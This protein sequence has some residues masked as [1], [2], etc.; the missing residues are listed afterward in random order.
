MDQ[1]TLEVDLH[2]VNNIR[3]SYFIVSNSVEDRVLT[4][5]ING[6]LAKKDVHRFLD[7][8]G[9]YYS[10]PV[11]KIIYT[12]VRIRKDLDTKEIVAPIFSTY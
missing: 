3:I 4:N 6:V 1:V 5:K 8:E 12:T 7:G 10:V 11:D 2:L 9:N